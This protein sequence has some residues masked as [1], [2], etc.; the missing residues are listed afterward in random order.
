MIGMRGAFGGYGTGVRFDV[1]VDP[2]APEAQQWLREELAKAPY[3]AARPTWF[4]RLS[5]GFLDWLG[6]LTLGEGDGLEGWISLVLTVLAI[7]AL[8][9]A[10][11]IFG[12]PRLNRRRQAAVTVFGAN[13]RRSAEEMRQSAR[14]AAASHDWNRAVQEM[15]RAIARG[16]EERTVLKPSP[17]TTAHEL[18]ARAG[19]VFPAEADRLADAARAFD[20]VRYLGRDVGEPEFTAVAGLESE[21][22]SAPARG[23]PP[24]APAVRS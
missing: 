14:R 16:L 1:P 21:L 15:Y 8:V 6:S 5:Q 2:D 23:L 18:A 24:V 4:D 7:A 9:V 3:Q 11:L 20:A 22:R 10:F 12:M 19:A 17:G 13:D